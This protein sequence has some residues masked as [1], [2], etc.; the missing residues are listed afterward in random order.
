MDDLQDLLFS[1][2]KSIHMNTLFPMFVNLKGKTCTVVGG[3]A[4]A[5]RKI[6]SLLECDA[7]VRVI[8]PKFVQ[9]IIQ[10]KHDQKIELHTR[11]YQA[12]DIVGSF[13]VVAAT[14]DTD[15]NEQIYQECTELNIL[16]NIVDTPELCNFYYASVYTCGDLKIAISTNGISPALT[17]KIKAELAEIY[18]DEFIPYLQYLQRI[19]AAVK[20]KIAEES[21][22]KKI[23]EK[24]VYDSTVLDQCKDERFCRELDNLDYSKEVD[25][26]L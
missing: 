8:A 1:L 13:L 19:R 12:H 16:C 11:P 7:S 21:I 4:V 9:Q 26:W 17:R 2:G 5:W 25:K 6:L 18:P 22:R 15:V 24:I 10:L 14:D 20:E 23:L 3:G